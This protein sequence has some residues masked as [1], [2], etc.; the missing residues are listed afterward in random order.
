MKPPVTPGELEIALHQLLRKYQFTGVGHISVVAVGP[1]TTP[2]YLVNLDLAAAKLLGEIL[3][4]VLGSRSQ[5][6]TTDWVLF[7]ADADA[8]VKLAR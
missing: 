1:E 6:R 8:I 7:Q 4:P 3:A 2:A 5:P